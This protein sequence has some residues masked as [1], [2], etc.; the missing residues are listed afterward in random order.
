MDRRPLAVEPQ[1]PPLPVGLA[2]D[3]SGTMGAAASF[4]EGPGGGDA[5][6]ILRFARDIEALTPMTTTE[7]EATAAVGGLAARGDTA[8]HDA[9]ARSVELVGQRPGGKAIVVLSDGVDDDGTGRPLGEA[10]VAEVLAAAHAVSVPILAVGLGTRM[11]EAVLREVADRTGALHLGAPSTE[12]PA[13]EELAAEELGSVHERIG[14]PLPVRHAIAHTSSLPADGT[15]RAGPPDLRAPGVRGGSRRGAGARAGVGRG[16]RGRRGGPRPSSAVPR[17]RSHRRGPA[18]RRARGDGPADRGDRAR[19][20]LPLR[21]HGGGHDG[22]AGALRPRPHRRRAARPDP[23]PSRRAARGDLRRGDPLEGVAGCFE[24]RAR[25]HDDDLIDAVV[26]DR[27]ME[28]AVRPLIE[29]VDDPDEAPH[30]VSGLYEANVIDAVRR[31]R[32]RD[33]VRARE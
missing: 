26:R 19:P 15:G 6:Q 30:R 2:I 24:V 10:T 18:Q 13:A 23:G 27:L 4:V 29:E 3:P 22:D 21:V 12:D 31:N 9:P 14:D 5:V 1:P 7:G 11:D 25:A 17:R 33:A 8:L 32:L 20:L 28:R 16:G